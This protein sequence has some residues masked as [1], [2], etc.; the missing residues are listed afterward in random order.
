MSASDGFLR[1]AKEQLA[2]VGPVTVRRMFGGAGLYANG[3]MFGLVADDT[4]YFKADDETRDLFE[5]EGLEPF[6]Y[7]GKGK[8]VRM[9]YWRAPDRV[10]DDRDAMTTWAKAAIGAAR[11][12]ASRK[13]PRRR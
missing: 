13:R 4:L 10:F 3:L 5:A 12:A 9:S 8:P 6:V 7:D 2:D 1:L 11:R